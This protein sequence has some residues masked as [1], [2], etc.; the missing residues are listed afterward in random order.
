MGMDLLPNFDRRTQRDKKLSS[1]VHLREGAKPRG[2]GGKL[3]S[4]GRSGGRRNCP[5]GP[6]TIKDN[7][8]PNRLLG[9]LVGT[10]GKKVPAGASSK[11]KKRI[12]KRDANFLKENIGVKKREGGSF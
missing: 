11:K 7:G 4:G 12:A 1:G 2:S 3:M 5:G 6:V 10:T 9:R 8:G